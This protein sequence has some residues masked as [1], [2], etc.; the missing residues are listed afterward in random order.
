[1]GDKLKELFARAIERGGF[2]MSAKLAMKT[3]LTSQLAA[4]TPDAPD[5]VASVRRALDELILEEM[6]TK[7]PA[8]ASV[9]PAG[10]AP[11]S[12]QA[13]G[14]RLKKY[15]DFARDRGGVVLTA[16]LAV[17]TCINTHMVAAVPD[18]AEN[19]AKVRKALV[20][21]LPGVDV[22]VF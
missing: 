16:K 17:K 5:V 4:T 6:R 19:V 15:F 8:A 14:G 7:A 9:K 1:M 11:T 22:P 2:P 10:P 21:L 18:T 20:E 13:G 3:C 12:A